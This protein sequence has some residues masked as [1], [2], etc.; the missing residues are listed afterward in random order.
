MRTDLVHA[1]ETLPG[2]HDSVVACQGEN[3]SAGESWSFSATRLS[4]E[5]D[6][7]LP[8]PLIAAIVS[9]GKVISLYM[10]GSY[11][12]DRIISFGRN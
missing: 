4:C 8:C 2:S 6:V 10:T 12:S 5:Y 1:H 3:H 7:D 9:N 11:V